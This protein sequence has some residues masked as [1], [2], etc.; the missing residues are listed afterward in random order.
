MATI[1]RKYIVFGDEHYNPL[2][3]VR[4][5]GEAGIRPILF[6]KKSKFKI[7][8]AS[9]YIFKVFYINSL[10]EGYEILL[11]HYGNCTLKPVLIP[12]DDQTVRYFDNKYEDL[13]DKFL[14]NNAGG[15][16]NIT[17]FLNKIHINSLAEKHGLKV[18]KTY[19][20]E[21][22]K[23]PEDIVYPVISKTVTS[24]SGK[25]KDDYYICNNEE[26]LK[27]AYKKIEGTDIFLQQF[28]TKKNELC[29]DGFCVKGKTFIAIASTYTY[30]LPGQ[31]SCRMRIKNFNNK[32]LEK[33]ISSIFEEIGF[34]G[35]FSIEFLIGEDNTLYF[36]EI[37][38][39]NSTWSYASTKLGMNL[40][41]LW[42]QGMSRGEI[43]QNIRK[44][45]PDGYTAMA[46]IPDF[47]WR[48]LSRKIGIIRWLKELKNTDCLFFYNKKD[49][50]PLYSTLYTKIKT[51]VIR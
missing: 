32:K 13:K 9:K 40:P 4:S 43:P 20:I 6:V 31:Y 28:I 18:A 51:K 11:K 41:V 48:V 7:V 38:F 15:N 12:C 16:N 36:L 1:E 42:A 14:F 3:V 27:D 2:G 49:P 50:K 26:E 30:L 45:I 35:I 24:Y 33:A 34:E 47:K 17:Y 22:G 25:W 19:L 29:L 10:D 23:I 21:K 39:R 5:L 8:S 46:E 44:K 37:N